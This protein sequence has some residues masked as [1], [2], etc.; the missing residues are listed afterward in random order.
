MLI[1]L[2]LLLPLKLS[3]TLAALLT[4]IL[5]PLAISSVRRSVPFA[6]M[7]L[8][9]I[10]MTWRAEAWKTVYLQLERQALEQRQPQQPPTLPKIGFSDPVLWPRHVAVGYVPPCGA[11]PFRFV[12]RAFDQQR[13]SPFV[14]VQPLGALPKN[15]GSTPPVIQSKD[16][17]VYLALYRSSSAKTF[18][19]LPQSYFRPRS[20]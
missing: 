1:T 17:P 11:I 16:R 3:V 8:A 19:S 18:V 13:L 4:A 2:A 20:G 14:G 9:L 15:N 10:G 5:L 7:T 6:A 12:I